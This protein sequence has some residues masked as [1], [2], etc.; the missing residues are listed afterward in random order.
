MKYT[1]N[2]R[3]K[4]VALAIKNAK[5]ILA[6]YTNKGFEKTAEKHGIAVYEDRNCYNNPVPAQAIYAESQ[7]EYCDRGE[8][9][10]TNY[11]WLELIEL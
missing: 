5:N 11:T 10:T 3:R 4:A 9:C 7:N 8:Y 2:A 1:E 6:Y